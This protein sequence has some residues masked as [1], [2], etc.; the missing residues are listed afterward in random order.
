MQTMCCITEKES[1]MLITDKYVFFW[2]GTSFSNWHPSTFTYKGMVF[3]CS[4]QAMMWEKAMTF[5]D[6]F[7]AGMVMELTNPAEQKKRGRKVLGYVDEIWAARRFDIVYEICL[8]KFTQNPEMK[9]EL[10]STGTRTIVEASPYDTI[11]GIGMGSND[12][13]V[14]DESKWKG[15]NLLGK[16]LMKVRENLI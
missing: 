11:W 13:D 16:V 3:N 6:D 15:E 4:E 9:E 14:L 8:A 12:P 2:G 5:F 10:L 1:R 7:T